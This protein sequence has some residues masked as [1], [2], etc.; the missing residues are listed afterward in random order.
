[1]YTVCSV[2]EEPGDDVLLPVPGQAR[3]LAVDAELRDHRAQQ[4]LITPATLHRLCHRRHQ[5]CHTMRVTG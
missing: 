2:G 5:V 3:R 1:M 4:P